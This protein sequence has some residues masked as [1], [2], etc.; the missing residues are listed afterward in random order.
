M[1]GSFDEPG[2]FVLTVTVAATVTVTVAVAPATP[3]RALAVAFLHSRSYA[4]PW[5]VNVCKIH[6]VRTASA[7]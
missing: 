6:S 3:V 4:L 7:S 5:G 1:P 2:I